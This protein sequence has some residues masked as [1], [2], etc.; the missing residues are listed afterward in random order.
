MQGFG[1]KMFR[2]VGQP[3]GRVG[4]QDGGLDLKPGDG[5]IAAA[6]APDGHFRRG[7]AGAKAAL[8]GERRLD[9]ELRLVAAE[10]FGPA[11]R[12]ACALLD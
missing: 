7:A 5:G 12:L 9:P 11:R 8:Q 4:G 2:E 1:L 10:D 3:V 6:E